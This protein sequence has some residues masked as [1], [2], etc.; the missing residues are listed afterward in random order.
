ME[1][2]EKIRDML[3]EAGASAAGF[4]RAGEVE[5]RD[6]DFFGRWLAQGCAGSLAYMHGHRDLREDPR[7]LLPGCA[8]VVATAW[9]YLPPRLRSGDLPFVARYAYGRDY[10]NALRSILRPVC[11]D[12]GKML[13]CAWRICI[14]S[15]PIRERYWAVR[16]GI[17]F[18]GRNGCLILPGQGS[19]QFIAL[20]LLDAALPP[21]SAGNAFMTCLQCGACLKA[22]PTGALRPDATVDTRRC[23]SAITVEG[24]PP[25]QGLECRLPLLGCDRCQE[26]CPHNRDAR[27]SEWARPSE[28]ILQLDAEELESMDEDTFAARFAG[29]SFRRP[30]LGVLRRNLG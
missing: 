1:P 21:D 23:L 12:I 3:L 9:N 27:P 13:G 18:I 30:G 14:D 10:H 4:A 16:G 5:E 22:C 24:T 17:G 29:T 6:K 8:T 19:W 2:K 28:E 26:V 7:L 15:A 11:R 25:P 20:I